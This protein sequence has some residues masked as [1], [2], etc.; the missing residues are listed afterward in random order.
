M[1]TPAGPEYGLKCHQ[2]WRRKC[3][4]DLEQ[5]VFNGHLPVEWTPD[6]ADKEEALPLLKSDTEQEDS[7]ASSQSDEDK[8]PK[9]QTP[10]EN[11]QKSAGSEQHIPKA[12]Q[13]QTVS[14]TGSTASLEEKQKEP[15][16]EIPQSKRYVGVNEWVRG[17]ARRVEGICR[18]D[19]SALPI[20]RSMAAKHTVEHTML[21][22][23]HLVTRKDRSTD[24]C[25]DESRGIQ[26]VGQPAPQRICRRR[27]ASRAGER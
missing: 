10:S 15:Y 4:T 14:S 9:T 13:S 27:S 12:S 5:R 17:F 20:F 3:G 8:Q 21:K 2:R 19:W 22:Q 18:A 16:P 26:S 1:I 11:E 25:V 6:D 23:A 7:S 24:A